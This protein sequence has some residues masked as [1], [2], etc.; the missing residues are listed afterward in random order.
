MSDKMVSF[1]TGRKPLSLSPVPIV[2]NV[3]SILG[4]FAKASDNIEYPVTATSTEKDLIFC[5]KIGSLALNHKNLTTENLK[6]TL[7]YLEASVKFANDCKVACDDA[8]EKAGE[9]VNREL[10]T[11]EMNVF[12][13]MD[14]MNANE[15]SVMKTVLD[16]LTAKLRACNETSDVVHP[17]NANNETMLMI[18]K[19]VSTKQVAEIKGKFTSR[20]R[21]AERKSARYSMGA[22]CDSQPTDAYVEEDTPSLNSKADKLLRGAESPPTPTYV[23][24]TKISS[25]EL[26]LIST[27]AG[28][29]KVSTAENL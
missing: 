6:L 24:S 1:K 9:V 23:F 13:S 15:L 25:T 11:E 26:F 28:T 16:L 5:E 2:F 19:H 14:T 8:I 22:S 20:K 10:S 7:D 27:T 21:P 4:A 29:S 12:E 3:I 17:E 18:V